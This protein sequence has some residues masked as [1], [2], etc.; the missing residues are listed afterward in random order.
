M[1][2][3]VRFVVL[4]IPS[5]ELALQGS[6]ESGSVLE[7]VA[8]ALRES[9]TPFVDLRESFAEREDPASL[10]YAVDGHW[11]RAGIDVA[12]RLLLTHIETHEV[13]NASESSS[14]G[15]RACAETGRDV[16]R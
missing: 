14:P 9:D 12:G 5:K 16:V 2:N 4:L 6:S 7:A 13:H 11:N 8:A 10:Y 3:D 1:A 15:S